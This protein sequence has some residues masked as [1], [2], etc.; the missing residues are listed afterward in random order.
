VFYAF[1]NPNLTCIFVDDKNASYLS[2]WGKDETATFVETEAECST[3][4]GTDKITYKNYLTVYP[5]PTK[6]KFKVTTNYKIKK[7]EIFDIYGKLVKTF[8]NQNDYS[9]SD[10]ESGVYLIYIHNDKGIQIAKLIIE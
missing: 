10:T 3:L 6:E 4:L 7:L 1:E 9:V 2:D 5:N 8:T